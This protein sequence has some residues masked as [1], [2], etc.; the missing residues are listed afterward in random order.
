MEVVA[1]DKVQL[2][3]LEHPSKQLAGKVEKLL[4]LAAVKNV[5]LVQDLKA[6]EPMVVKLVGNVT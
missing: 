4:A 5:S 2:L 1:G 3:K 6:L